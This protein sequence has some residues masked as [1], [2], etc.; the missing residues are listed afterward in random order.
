MASAIDAEFLQSSELFQNQPRSVVDALLAKGSLLAFGSGQIV[1]NQGDPGDRLYI[2]K[3][4]VVEIV[5][6]P[7]DGSE[8]RIVAYLGRGEVIGE[9]ALLTGSSRSATVRAPEL[10]EL[11]TV[12]TP[13]FL[14]LLGTLPSFARNLCVVLARRLESTTLNAP[15]SPSKQLQG[16]LRFFDLA[17]VMQTL[18]SSHQT[19]VLA[20]R[21]QG[22]EGEKR[23]KI[24]EILFFKGNISRAKFRHLI[25]DDAVF[26]LFQSPLDGE[27]AF[28]GRNMPEDEVQSDITMPAISLLMES[29]RLQDELPVLKQ[30]LSDP[31]RV[32]SQKAPELSWSDEE[33]V[34]LAAAVWA[35]LKNGASLAEL[36]AEIPR[37]SYAVY[38]TVDTLLSAGQIE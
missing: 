38:K 13:V 37:C 2:V 27:F 26:Q 4:G 33:S 31:E 25:G 21:Q 20:V 30:R 24:A 1:F 35:R 12:E 32:F 10:A 22:G 7:K 36:E 6:T 8:P 9:L 11:F 19:G 17:T 16:N 14:D 29:V 15:A 34:E 18:I 23:R 5:A 28:T 3:E